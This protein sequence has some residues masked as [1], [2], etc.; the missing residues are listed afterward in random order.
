MTENL[1]RV[2]GP[3]Q[4]KG[5]ITKGEHS[6]R[7]GLCPFSKGNYCNRIVF[8][9]TW[10]PSQKGLLVD[11]SHWEQFL[12]SCY[13]PSS[14]RREV[15]AFQSEWPPLNEYLLTITHMRC[16]HWP[17]DYEQYFVCLIG[18]QIYLS[19]AFYSYGH[20]YEENLCFTS[21]S[22]GNFVFYWSVLLER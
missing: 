8:P 19:M 11:N 5:Y 4:M 6:K 7:K 1:Q 17:R 15:N 20:T 10:I 16:L 9:V 21:L 13:S 14:F 22:L 3:L 18:I 12:P 2:S